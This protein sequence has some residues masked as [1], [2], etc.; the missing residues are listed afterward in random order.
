[1]CSSLAVS[2][3]PPKQASI[4]GV[5]PSLVGKSTGNPIAVEEDKSNDEE[6]DDEDDEDDVEEEEEEF[7]C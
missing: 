2:R 7:D 3:W 6:E 4:K 1:M 5:D